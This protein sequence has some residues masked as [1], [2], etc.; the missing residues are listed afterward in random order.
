MDCFIV[1]ADFLIS[2]NQIMLVSLQ[3]LHCHVI[4]KMLVGRFVFNF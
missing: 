4:F 3:G 2:V 1:I